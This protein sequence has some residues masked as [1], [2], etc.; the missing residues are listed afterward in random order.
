MLT[1]S[2]SG[3]L[4]PYYYKGGSF[5]GIHYG[6]YFADHEGLL[7]MMAKEEA[8]ILAAPAKR[9]VMMDLYQTKLPKPVLEQMVEHIRRLA[10]KL[11]KL[12]ISAENGTLRELEKALR[13]AEILPEGALYLHPDME[14]AK[15]W[16]VGN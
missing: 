16:L 14:T 15:T 1:K 5:H 10:P 2:P 8:F 12:A 3:A 9:R 4:S 6:G 13:K 11:H 7:A